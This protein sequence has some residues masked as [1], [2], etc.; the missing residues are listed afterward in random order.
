MLFYV[1]IVDIVTPVLYPNVIH[2]GLLAKALSVALAV[3][4]P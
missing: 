4:W 3:P 1:F 2:H